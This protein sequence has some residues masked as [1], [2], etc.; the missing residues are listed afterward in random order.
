MVDSLVAVGKQYEEQRPQYKDVE[1]YVEHELAWA[2]IALLRLYC[3]ET[4][5]DR[6][7]AKGYWPWDDGWNPKTP[8]DVLTKAGAFIITELERIK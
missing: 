3:A 7:V 1:K 8:R 5:G 2:A 6:E 4:L